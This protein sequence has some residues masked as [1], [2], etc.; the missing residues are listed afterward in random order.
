MLRGA[1]VLAADAAV[2]APPDAV[3]DVAEAPGAARRPAGFPGS[4]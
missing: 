4:A 1:A 3:E 2:D